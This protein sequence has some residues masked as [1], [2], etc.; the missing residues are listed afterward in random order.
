MLIFVGLNVWNISLLYIVLCVNDLLEL[1]LGSDYTA[2]WRD[3][4]WKYNASSCSYIIEE[5]I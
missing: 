4:V 5:H 3:Q 1:V 2:P